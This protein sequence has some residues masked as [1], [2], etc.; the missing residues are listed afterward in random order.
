MA[1]LQERNGSFRILFRYHGKQYTYPVGKVDADDADL[2]PP[3][4]QD[5]AERLAFVRRP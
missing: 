3:A 2:G 4:H 5:R 1:A